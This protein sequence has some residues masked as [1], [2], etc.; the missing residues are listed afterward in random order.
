MD[1]IEHWKLIYEDGFPLEVSSLGRV[2]RLHRDLEIAP[3]NHKG[4]ITG[5]FRKSIPA[6]EMK[7]WKSGAGYMMVSYMRSGVR[8]K[9]SVHRLVAK[10]FVDGWFQD[11]T[12]DHVDGNRLN[13]H[14]SNLQWVTRAENTRRQ[15]ADGRGVPK[16]EA[17]PNAKLRNAQIQE[18]FEMRG[19]GI[20]CEKIGKHFNVSGS[21]IHK[22]TTGKRRST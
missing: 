20:S 4:Q 16:G 21:L 12:V 15:N 8:Y 13:N 11:A 19:K 1:N 6:G 17:H 10:A 9:K 22:I 5:N 14:A 18:I 7:Q 2:R 3:R